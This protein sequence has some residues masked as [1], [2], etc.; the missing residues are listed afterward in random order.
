MTGAGVCD[1]AHHGEP[2]QWFCPA[3][4]SAPRRST[5]VSAGSKPAAVLPTAVT[6][7]AVS[8]AATPLAA[9][10]VAGDVATSPDNSAAADWE[11]ICLTLSG[12]GAAYG[13]LVS[14]HQQAI[15]RYVWRFSRDPVVHE[16]LVQ[17]VFVEAYFQ[18]RTFAGRS[19]WFHWLQV[20]ATRVGFRHWKS[21][22]RVR[23]RGV[24][25]LDAATEPVMK[26]EISRQLEESEAA[27]RVHATLQQLPPRD[28]LVITLLHLEEKSIAEI[29]ELT[30][31]SRTMVK[32]QAYRARAKLARLIKEP[33]E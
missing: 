11:D 32:V 8:P 22:S 10:T 14:R 25:A 13:R 9:A 12:D 6:S 18:L 29:A 1:L 4:S 24:V 5:A 20:I 21:Q 31:W 28:R 15:A 2:M 3:V 26:A 7:A 23:A 27:A 33:L 19:P 16:D 30:G 17:T